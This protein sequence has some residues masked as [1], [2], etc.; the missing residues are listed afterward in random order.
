[1]NYLLTTRGLTPNVP[2]RDVGTEMEKEWQAI[3][4]TRMTKAARMER[5]LIYWY[6]KKH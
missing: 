4:S 1:M 3:F 6:F 5:Y 2:E